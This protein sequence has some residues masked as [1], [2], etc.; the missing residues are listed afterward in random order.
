VGQAEEP[1]ARVS[2]SDA[3]D[4]LVTP[5]RLAIRPRVLED[6]NIRSVAG[7]D[8]VLFRAVKTEES[9]IRFDPVSAVFRGG[10]QEIPADVM[11]G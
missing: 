5:I 10:V 6:A 4:H 1:D 3:V 7:D 2:P 8:V 11:N 9:Q